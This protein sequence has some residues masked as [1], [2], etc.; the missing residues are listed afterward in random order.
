VSIDKENKNEGRGA[1]LCKNKSCFEKA[2]KTQ[3]LNRAYKR[4]IDKNIYE[5]L[6]L[7]GE[8]FE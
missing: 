7:R 1:Y 8:D 6:K 2:L 3:V 4:Q 5:E